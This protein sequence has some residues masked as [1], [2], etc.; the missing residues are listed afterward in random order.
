M[1]KPIA[2]II[3]ELKQMTEEQSKREI[4]PTTLLLKKIKNLKKKNK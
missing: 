3:N 2:L 1:K 4:E